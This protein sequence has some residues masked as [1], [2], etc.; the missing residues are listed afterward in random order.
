M[1]WLVTPANGRG[2]TAHGRRVPAAG[3]RLDEPEDVRPFE[4]DAEFQV[5]ELP[6]GDPEPPARR[7]RSRTRD[8]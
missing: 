3:V 4:G 1:T 7:G 5:D 8:A 6:A 2:R